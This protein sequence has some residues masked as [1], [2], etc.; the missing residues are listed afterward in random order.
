M[1]DISDHICPQDVIAATAEAV[2]LDSVRGILAIDGALKRYPGDARLHFLRG[3]VLAGLQRYEEARAAMA[4]ALRI[5]PGFALARFQLGFLELTSGAPAAAEAT[6]A[7]LATLPEDHYLLIFVGA[8]GH[9]IRD[10]FAETVAQLMRG[11]K[12]NAENPEINGN[13]QLIIDQVSE[14][15][16]VPLTKEA[17]SEAHLLLQRY[18]RPP[19]RH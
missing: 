17:I 19:T 3:S 4:E 12:R 6:W 13:M 10:E 11:I 2:R 18:P 5:A 1:S 9:L 14:K 15:H 7:P 8:L 16:L